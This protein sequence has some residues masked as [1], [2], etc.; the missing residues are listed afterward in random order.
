MKKKLLKWPLRIAL[1]LMLLIAI[2][3]GIVWWKIDVAAQYVVES[4]AMQAT[5]QPTQTDGVHVSLLS[6]N[7]S[8]NDLSTAN[9]TGY[10]AKHILRTDSIGVS[11]GLGSLWT[12][13]LRVPE[14]VIQGLELHIEQ[15]GLKN[16]VSQ[17]LEQINKAADQRPAN[18]QGKK[19]QIDR[20]V[21]KDIVAHVQLLPL[22]GQASSVE[23][24]IPELILDDVTPQAT[25]AVVVSEAIRRIIPAI[26]VA[27]LEQGQGILPD[28]LIAGIGTDL[29]G[30]VTALGD[31]AGKLI[32]QVA[33]DLG[34][35]ILK[36]RPGTL[37]KTAEEGLKGLGEGLKGVFDGK[38]QEPK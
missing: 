35:T 34:K 29:K 25:Q 13:T 10:Q 6:G 38:K 37:G 2:A 30:T 12:D 19:L 3:L 9:I 4:G 22:G 36:D 1:A 7:I 16:N 32:G 21:L 33:D 20:V 5:G 14:I 17:L 11:V 15:K 28:D 23:I 18:A 31:E 27:V 8:I 26:I 24:K